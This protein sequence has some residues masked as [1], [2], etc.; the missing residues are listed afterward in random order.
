MLITYVE[1]RCLVLLGIGVIQINIAN[2]IRLKTNIPANSKLDYETNHQIERELENLQKILENFLE[3]KIMK[4]NNPRNSDKIQT[5]VPINF[6]CLHEVSQIQTQLCIHS[7]A[8]IWRQVGR[9]QASLSGG[10]Q[11]TPFQ[12]S[13]LLK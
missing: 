6:S 8:N 1:I 13:V 9:Q 5:K 3:K 10:S 12:F 7:R 11:N 4:K 2:E